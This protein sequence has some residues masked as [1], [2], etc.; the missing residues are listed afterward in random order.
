LGVAQAWELR[1]VKSAL[2]SLVKSK[3]QSG[4]MHRRKTRLEDL[5][6]LDY[7]TELHANLRGVAHNE[8]LWSWNVLVKDYLLA[9]Q[10]YRDSIGEGA[11]GHLVPCAYFPEDK[12]VI[13]ILLC[14]ATYSSDS[15]QTNPNK[16][17]KVSYK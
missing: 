1:P 15:I 16:R 14:V 3:F 17:L 7:N 4:N 8:S 10:S 11:F 13:N 9:R 5:Y 12:D 2:H 6:T